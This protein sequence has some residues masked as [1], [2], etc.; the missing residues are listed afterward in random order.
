MKNVI[1]ILTGIVLNLYIA[2]GNIDILTMLMLPIHEH[3]IAFH[4]FMSSSISFNNIY[5]FQCT[6]LSPPWLNLFLGILLFVLL[7]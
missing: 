4:F 1:G 6:D 5:C 2:L 7:L 3:G